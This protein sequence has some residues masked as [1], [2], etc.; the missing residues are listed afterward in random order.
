[1]MH[2]HVTGE[3]SALDSPCLGV[4]ETP[5]AM[6]Q[7]AIRQLADIDAHFERERVRV[8]ESAG[9]KVARERMLRELDKSCIRQRQPLVL[10]LAS[11]HQRQTV[12]AL[13]PIKPRIA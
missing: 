3:R 6:V 4:P 11:L 9:S 13:F 8:Q 2:P 12:A 1:M 7:D 5:E 10:L